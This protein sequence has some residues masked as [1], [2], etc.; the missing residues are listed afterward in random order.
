[1]AR[2]K[3]R[4]RSNAIGRLAG[5]AWR[6]LL[7]TCLAF[8]LAV[9]AASALAT[10]SRAGE[11]AGIESPPPDDALTPES[12]EDA[13]DGSP[14]STPPHDDDVSFGIPAPT[15]VQ[16]P[17]SDASVA[18]Y[19]SDAAPSSSSGAHME[20]NLTWDSSMF[21]SDTTM[22]S[23]RTEL[24]RSTASR[25]TIILK[26]TLHIQLSDA[27]FKK[28]EAEIRI[29]SVLGN[30]RNGSAV[31]LKS[32]D[33]GLGTD[34][35]KAT[36]S[37]PFYYSIDSVTKECV[38]RNAF[39]LSQAAQA[40]IEI[41]YSVDPVQVTDMSSAGI[42]AQGTFPDGNGGTKT[43]VS[44]ETLKYTLD[45][46]I[47]LD[48]VALKSEM[49]YFWPDTFTSNDKTYPPPAMDT[50]QYRYVKYT[51]NAYSPLGKDGRLG[52]QIYDL[53]LKFTPD[54]GG[55]VVYQYLSSTRWQNASFDQSTNTVTLRADESLVRTGDVLAGSGTSAFFFVVAY[56]KTSA[57]SSYTAKLEGKATPGDHVDQQTTAEASTTLTWR[58]YEFAYPTGNILAFEKNI[59]SVG[60]ASL[61]LLDAGEDTSAIEYTLR[62]TTK[63]YPKENDPH[64]PDVSDPMRIGAVITDDLLYLSTDNNSYNAATK[65][66]LTGDD[67]RIA[68]ASLDIK[69]TLTDRSS[70]QTI[71]PDLSTEYPDAHIQVSF[72]VQGS[73]AWTVADSYPLAKTTP[74][75]IPTNAFRIRVDIPSVLKDETEAVLTVGHVIRGTSPT[76]HETRDPDNASQQLYLFNY[77]GSVATAS[78]GTLSGL[79]DESRYGGTEK[80][81]GMPAFDHDNYGKYLLRKY[82]STGLSAAPRFS[83]FSKKATGSLKNEGGN[84]LLEFELKAVSGYGSN[85][86]KSFTLNQ[87]KTLAAKG[88]PS[89]SLDRAVFYDLL[90]RGAR[91]VTTGDQAPKAK[92]LGSRAPAP[93]VTVSVTNNYRNTDRQLVKIEV[94]S[95]L[96]AGE[97]VYD[98][99]F[100]S[101]YTS[102]KGA[103]SGYSATLWVSVPFD[104]VPLVNTTVNT[105][106]FQNPDAGLIGGG[107]YSPASCYP[108]TGAAP[109]L[110]DVKGADGASAF[111]NLA[112]TP[113]GP[114]ASVK[115]TMYA[116]AIMDIKNSVSYG[117]GLANSVKTDTFIDESLYASSTTV[118]TGQPYLYRLSLIS[119]TKP[120]SN[121]ILFDNFGQATV[122]GSESGWNGTF[123]NVDLSNT[124]FKGIKP[125]VYYTTEEHAPYFTVDNITNNTVPSAWSTDEPSDK[126]SVRGIAV[127]I[128]HDE[129]GNTY[130]IPLAQSVSL[131]IT[132]RAPSALP[133]SAL[134]A[135]VLSDTAPNEY[136]Q[137]AYYALVG[138][139]P[140]DPNATALIAPT[141]TTKLVEPQLVKANSPNDWVSQ[142][143]TITYTLS[144]M[145]ETTETQPL[146]LSDTAP[147]G[148][149]LAPANAGSALAGSPALTVGDTPVSNAATS[150]ATTGAVSWTCTVPPGKTVSATYEVVVGLAAQGE[151][152]N[153]ASALIEDATTNTHV[154]FDSNEVVNRVKPPLEKSVE[155]A[156]AS[157]IKTK[158]GDTLTYTLKYTNKTSS[159][160]KVVIADAAPTGTLLAGGTGN[161]ATAVDGTPVGNAASVTGSTVTWT[162]DP[163][164]PNSELAVSFQVVVNADAAHG[165]TVENTGMAYIDNATVGIES[166]P[167]D[168]TIE[169]PND[170]VTPPIDPPDP[171][172]TPDPGEPSDPVEPS[173]P[174]P[175]DPGAD[176][177]PNTPPT[178]ATGDPGKTIAARTG[179]PVFPVVLAGAI[180]AAAAIASAAAARRARR[181]GDK[182]R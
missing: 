9:P 90:P 112:N 105:A 133:A 179:D 157:R 174:E 60:T 138:G 40:Y 21:T 169:K 20:L 45:T 107:A 54:T 80:T 1:M 5:A 177:L 125:V 123:E 63:Y 170:P 3:A 121:A 88:L 134:S 26:Y 69:N 52:N 135:S 173:D 172:D 156:G 109:N 16:D 167:V 153:T 145:N 141:V 44:A 176:P 148:T 47:E 70:G 146:A 108:D 163:L 34:P 81:L 86:S 43:V 2:G 79:P 53:S 67:Y 166:N 74:I 139:N 126:A 85:T 62:A 38:I 28:D 93:S 7:A 120:I 37:V 19:L 8:S 152:R 27:E 89:A 71:T 137:A 35:S 111:Y 48:S 82:K 11:N 154:P 171:P 95:N 64:Y 132:M 162:I 17:L 149:S 30:Y 55:T 142:Q 97:N 159:A 42:S 117:D 12:F 161:P 96:P 83:S 127:D 144:Y 160:Q 100:Y 49:M 99:I 18:E 113:G 102:A 75:R 15:E 181:F 32:S 164:Q 59:K 51:A 66:I 56:P 143:D 76:Y 68:S 180:A 36:E 4:N 14:L 41:A 72:M 147:A 33:I 78:G 140:V 77:A 94:A 175:S 116:S 168:T 91:I 22:S 182:H 103:M 92:N 57:A 65:H 13:Q 61:D 29:P 23:D 155:T 50:S 122:N 119:G 128:S 106:A 24:V 115:N 129:A 73:S 118:L 101:Q 98:E 6:A 114:D 150:D 31:T 10:E 158:P 165:S 104:D 39:D 131:Y 87:Y 151:I 178:V 58:D 136:N 25:S 110:E 130:A 84:A 124:I 46:S